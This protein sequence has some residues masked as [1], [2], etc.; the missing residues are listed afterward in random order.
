MVRPRTNRGAPATCPACRMPGAV[1]VASKS[2]RAGRGR[3]R[4]RAAVTP[5]TPPTDP[6]PIGCGLA[7]PS[8]PAGRSYV[9][10]FYSSGL[11]TGIY[12]GGGTHELK[13]IKII[14]ARTAIDMENA[15]ARIENLSIE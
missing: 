3:K 7:L 15:T 12:A 8:H 6:Q 5:E 4:G 9:G 2:T 1:R 13:D 10:K 14:G 11:A